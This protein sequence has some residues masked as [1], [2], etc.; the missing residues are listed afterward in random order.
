MEELWETQLHLTSQIMATQ[1]QT[2]LAEERLT[3]WMQH[4]SLERRRRELALAAAGPKSHSLGVLDKQEP[5]ANEE[6]Q[7]R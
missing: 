3:Y 2:E 7:R 1:G 5:Q 6:S 4:R